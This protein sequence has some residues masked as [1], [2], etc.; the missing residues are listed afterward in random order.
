MTEERV[1]LEQFTKQVRPLI[2]GAL[3]SEQ[4]EAAILKLRPANREL[5]EAQRKGQSRVASRAQKSVDLFVKQLGIILN[6]KFPDPQ[7][8][9]IILERRFKQQFEA[10]PDE[11]KRKENSG[12]MGSKRPKMG[13]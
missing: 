11:L 5:E 9:E 13:K 10:L 4:K 8:A 7:S 1:N 3:L 12:S 2:R 6:G